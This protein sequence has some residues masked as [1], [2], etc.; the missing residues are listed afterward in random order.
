MIKT[1]MKV[2]SE[3][4]RYGYSVELDP[5]FADQLIMNVRSTGAL[6]SWKILSQIFIK[7]VHM[8]KCQNS[9]FTSI[10]TKIATAW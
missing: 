4:S 7:Y 2:V 5:K 3:I 9:E 10:G 1:V 6:S 8:Y